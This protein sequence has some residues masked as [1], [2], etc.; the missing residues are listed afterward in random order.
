MNW[1]Y[2]SGTQKIS[3]KLIEKYK[4][5]VHWGYIS[6]YQTLSEDF[7][8]KFADEVNWNSIFKFQKNLSPEFREEFK[9][10]LM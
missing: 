1:T 9:D 5:K 4:D 7:I 10:R 3:E 8:R 2:I 6:A